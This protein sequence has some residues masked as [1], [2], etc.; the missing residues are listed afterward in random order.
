LDS[1]SIARDQRIEA[2]DTLSLAAGSV[3]GAP[4]AGCSMAIAARAFES[5]DSQALTPQNIIIVAESSGETAVALC[6]PAWS[7]DSVR[8]DDPSQP[9]SERFC[10]FAGR[11]NRSCADGCNSR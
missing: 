10:A 4:V 5:I 2:W 8:G 3:T 11:T 1:N 7:L 9:K 6:R